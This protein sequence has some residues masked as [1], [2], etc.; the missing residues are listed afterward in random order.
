MIDKMNMNDYISSY[1]KLLSAKMYGTI[2]DI[3]S[4]NNNI[5][6]YCSTSNTSHNQVVICC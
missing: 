4:I 2:N 1:Y 5:N 3:L 6:W